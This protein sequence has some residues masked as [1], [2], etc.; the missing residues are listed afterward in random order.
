MKFSKR[1]IEVL[2]LL[3]TGKRQKEIAELL[4]ISAKTVYTFLE[5]AQR[6]AGVQ[7]TNELL[8]FW[9]REK[10]HAGRVG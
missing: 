8:V 5:R 2:D 7:T 10:P 9:V 6:K 1:Q 4:K 3:A